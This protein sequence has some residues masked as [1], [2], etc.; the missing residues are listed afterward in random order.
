MSTLTFKLPAFATAYIEVLYPLAE[1]YALEINESYSVLNF[2]AVTDAFL[3]LKATYCDLPDGALTLL[4]H[5]RGGDECLT[6]SVRAGK[7][8]VRAAADGEIP[9]MELTHTDAI[10]LLFSTFCP[11]RDR[12]PA[13]ARIWLPLPLWMYAADEV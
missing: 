10:N 3:A 7:T 5:G 11:L 12:L 4:I 2:A 8:E 9:A 1:G 6:L 13:H